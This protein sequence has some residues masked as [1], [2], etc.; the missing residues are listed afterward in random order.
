MNTRFHGLTNLIYTI[1]AIYERT[2]SRPIH[3]TFKRTRE[4]KMQGNFFFYKLIHPF[5]DTITTNERTVRLLLH[6]KGERKVRRYSRTYADTK[7]TGPLAV[8][9]WLRV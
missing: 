1:F 4:K 3:I 5:S 9:V 2:F 8:S 7:D 6:E